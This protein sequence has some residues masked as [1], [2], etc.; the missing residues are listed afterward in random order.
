MNLRKKLITTI[1]WD[2]DGTLYDPSEIIAPL[3]N[4][5]FKI[6]TK[7]V[8]P[9]ITIKKFEEL[10][11]SYGSW[12]KLLSKKLS[13]PEKKLTDLID[14]KFPKQ[15]FIKKNEK[16]VQKIE[17]LKKYNHILLSNSNTNEVRAGLAKIGFKKK[18]NSFY[19]FLHILGRDQYNKM[20]PHPEGFTLVQKITG[21]PM[22]CHLSIG[23]S[24]LHDLEPAKK[25]GMQELH[26]SEIDNFFNF[27]N[28]QK[29]NSWRKDTKGYSSLITNDTTF[30][31]STYYNLLIQPILS[32]IKKYCQNNSQATILDVGCGEGYLTR[33]IHSILPEA[34]LFGIDISGELLKIAKKKDS[35]IQYTQANIESALT[36]K[37][38]KLVSLIVSNLVII[39]IKNIHNYWKNI[40][41]HLDTEGIAI[42]SLPHPCFNQ[43]NNQKWFASQKINEDLVIQNYNLE[44]KFNKKIVDFDTH[45]YHRKLE[46]YIKTA[47]ENN[48]QVIEILEPQPMTKSENILMKK[49]E[50][51]PFYLILVLKKKS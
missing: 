34:Q 26:I 18:E 23:D 3:R 24:F 10:A 51:I 19:P 9:H 29:N 36:I 11:T 22:I 49:A 2:F 8:D 39:Y 41:K 6:Y 35:S 46:T 27:T 5:Y 33:E 48:L 14:K 20:K 47:S 17:S 7:K 42:I 12:S 4:V 1:I 38:P 30:F 15:K 25:L 13:L 44:N 43:Q 32:L 45:H 50:K 28:K 16:L 21:H 40:S 37:K 31:E